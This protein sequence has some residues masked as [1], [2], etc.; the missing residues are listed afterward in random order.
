MIKE[1][2]PAI[3]AT[4]SEPV[5][6]FTEIYENWLIETIIII[7]IIIGQYSLSYNYY[8]ATH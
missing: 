7:I 5:K 4:E 6:Y 3:Y 1:Y 2:G 8:M